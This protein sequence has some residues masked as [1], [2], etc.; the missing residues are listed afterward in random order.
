[1]IKEFSGNLQ[2][3]H[4]QQ[5]QQGELFGIPQRQ[6]EPVAQPQQGEQNASIQE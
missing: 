1:M 2:P 3:P 4:R 5:P 6:P